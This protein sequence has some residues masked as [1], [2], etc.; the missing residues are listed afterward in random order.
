[1]YTVAVT[2]F[3]GKSGQYFLKRLLKEK[4]KLKEDF[5]I[6]DSLINETLDIINKESI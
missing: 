1:M 2:G 5:K 6:K 4:A 3:T